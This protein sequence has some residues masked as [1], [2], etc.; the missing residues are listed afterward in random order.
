[1][2]R[3]VLRYEGAYQRFDVFS[4]TG[5]EQVILVA[6]LPTNGVIHGLTFTDKATLIIRG[7]GTI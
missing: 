3:W 4:G 6:S 7:E 2:I 5:P 1:M